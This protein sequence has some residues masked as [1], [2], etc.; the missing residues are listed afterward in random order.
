MCVFTGIH[1]TNHCIEFI[2]LE[3]KQLF[4]NYSNVI[5][6]RQT[7][8]QRLSRAAESKRR[9][10][11][12]YFSE[13]ICCIFQISK[14]R[15]DRDLGLCITSVLT[16]CEHQSDGKIREKRKCFDVGKTDFVIALRFSKR[17]YRSCVQP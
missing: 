9:A 15:V 14:C 16:F 7:C 5:L 1:F 13:R 4:G 10:L 12:N 6:T 17:T 8:G 3:T 2:F 11:G